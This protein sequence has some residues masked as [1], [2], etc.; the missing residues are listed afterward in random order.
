[1]GGIV[2]PCPAGMPG[3]AVPDRTMVPIGASDLGVSQGHVPELPV[4]MTLSEAVREGIWPGRLPAMQKA[5]Q[6][7]GFPE[8]VG[9]RGNA[10][11]WDPRDLYAY[12]AGRNGRQ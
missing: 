9:W 4:G 12:V 8:P 2:T 10:R 6:R 5:S 11:V 7:A 1:M 3:I